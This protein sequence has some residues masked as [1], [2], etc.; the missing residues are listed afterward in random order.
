MGA[1]NSEFN[2]D[3]AATAKFTSKMRIH[4]LSPIPSNSV[5]LLSA[6]SQNTSIN[7]LPVGRVPMI[8]ITLGGQ[9]LHMRLIRFVTERDRM[10]GDSLLY[11]SADDV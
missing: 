10:H 1:A 5:G 11:G 6:I 8:P 7:S 2:R 4:Q 9:G 3:R